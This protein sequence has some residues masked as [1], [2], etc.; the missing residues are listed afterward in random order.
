MNIKQIVGIIIPILFLFIFVSPEKERLLNFSQTIFGKLVFVCIILFYAETN[1]MYGFLALVF[2]VFYYKIFFPLSTTTQPVVGSPK[3]V[4][5]KRTVEP[6]ES[7]SHVPFIIYQTWHSRTLP[8]KM[9]KCVEKLKLDNPEF[10]H[11]LY[12]DADCRVFIAENFDTSVLDAYDAL[13]PGAYK[14]DLWRYCVL[15]K[16]GGVYLDIKFQCEPGFSLKELTKDDETFILDRPYGDLSLPT[17]V[18][19]SLL[20]SPTFYDMLHDQTS[21]TW[22][23]KQIGL[24]NAVMASYP[25]NPVLYECI[26]HIVKNVRNGYYG[27]N[28]IYPTGPGLLGEVYFKRNYHSKVKKIRYFNS[29]AGNSILSKRRKILSHYPEYRIEQQTYTAN[30]PKFYYHDL[31]QKKSVYTVIVKEKE[32]QQRKKV[33][34]Q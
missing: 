28:P 10:E 34:N 17:D 9:A 29:I 19:L 2:V 8:P 15:Y 24:Y 3:G 22:K 12:D 21:N 26:Q 5:T 7:E 20:N 18:N 14:A 30:G 32:Q 6:D 27:Y 4:V 23:N 33:S 25:N 11:H 31:W 1:L 16:K 13:I